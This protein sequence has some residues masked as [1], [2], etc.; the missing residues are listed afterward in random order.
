M[1]AKIAI[2]GISAIYAQNHDDLCPDCY[3]DNVEVEGVD[4]EYGKQK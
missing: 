3:S 2:S 4:N 1:I